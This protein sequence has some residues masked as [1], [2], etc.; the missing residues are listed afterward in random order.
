[1]LKEKEIKEERENKPDPGP[2][3]SHPLEAADILKQE[4]KLP[5]FGN[6]LSD[7]EAEDFLLRMNSPYTVIPMMLD[8]FGTD[9]RVGA[10]LNDEIRNIFKM[11]VF[12]PGSYFVGGEREPITVVPIPSEDREKKL[13]TRKGLLLTDMETMSS[14]LRDGITKLV[15]AAANRASGSPAE[16][17]FATNFLHVTDIAVSI[18]EAALMVG[19]EAALSVAD[20]IR[21]CVMQDVVI[22]MLGKWIRELERGDAAKADGNVSSLPFHARLVFVHANTLT[23]LRRKMKDPKAQREW[24]SQESRKKE[25]EERGEK[26]FRA[27]FYD[28]TRCFLSSATAVLKHNELINGDNVTDISKI[29]TPWV[30]QG[31][32]LAL[33][34][35]QQ[36]CI[37]ATK[38]GDQNKVLNSIAISAYGSQVACSVQTQPWEPCI[39]T[40][41]LCEEN[42]T[43]SHPYTPGEDLYRTLHFPGVQFISI[44]FDARTKT[45]GEEDYVTIFKDETY[46]SYWGEERYYGKCEVRAC[47]FESVLVAEL[48]LIN[49]H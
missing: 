14:A 21:K 19:D 36:S 38:L 47:Y 13:A 35:N 45:S 34:D 16:S 17:A 10:L 3:P 27:Y 2:Y 29:W 24:E 33:M 37:E 42:I 8:F 22:K 48:R 41:T 32:F 30:F 4:D 40:S 43:T 15:S 28:V 46:S 25:L 5:N 11:A 39:F 20:D 7:A 6:V 18:Q 26:D 1:M 12:Q 44:S 49:L 9:D 23:F 31:V